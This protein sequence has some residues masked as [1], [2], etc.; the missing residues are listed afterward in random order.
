MALLIT[1]L[2]SFMVRARIDGLLKVG[3]LYLLPL[4]VLNLILT[5]AVLMLR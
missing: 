4:S 3:W 5:F 1:F 2:R